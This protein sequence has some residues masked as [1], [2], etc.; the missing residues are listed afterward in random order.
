MRVP[1]SEVLDDLMRQAPPGET[2]LAWIV[3]HLR[4]RSFGI[5]MLLIGIL[6]LCAALASIAVTAAAVWGT[7]EATLLL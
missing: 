3:E 5:V 7:V 1:T 4:D 6:A 2:T